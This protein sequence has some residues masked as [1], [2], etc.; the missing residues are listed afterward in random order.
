VLLLSGLFTSSFQKK[1]LYSF[2]IFP[3]NFPFPPVLS[4]LIWSSSFCMEKNANYEA[5]HYAVFSSLPLFYSFR[6]KFFHHP[7]RTLVPCCEESDFTPIKRTRKIVVCIYF[8]NVGVTHMTGFGLDDWIYC[9]FY[10][11]T[12]QGYRQCSAIAILHTL[13]SPLHTH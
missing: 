11:H 3:P 6:S 4:S 10:I 2:H 7:Q 13:Q 1:K 5:P 9:A 8:S 12:V